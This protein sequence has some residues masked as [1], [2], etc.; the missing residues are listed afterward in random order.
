MIYSIL[1]SQSVCIFFAGCCGCRTFIGGSERCERFATST[2]WMKF[3]DYRTNL[4][5][6]IFIRPICT[7]FKRRILPNPHRHVRDYTGFYAVWKWCRVDWYLYGFI[8]PTFDACSA[9]CVFF[10]NKSVSKTRTAR[11][12]IDWT[13]RNNNKSGI[14]SCGVITFRSR[15]ARLI[16]TPTAV[17]PHI[18]HYRIIQHKQCDGRRYAE[19]TCPCDIMSSATFVP[20]STNKNYRVKKKENKI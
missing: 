15:V 18:I 12:D 6:R 10:A 1:H 16:Q 20:K 14:I 19:S 7:L 8:M 11:G 3:V 9:E 2:E 17:S 5:A 4:D 13:G